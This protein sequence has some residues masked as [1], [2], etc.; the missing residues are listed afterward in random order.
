[1]NEW[2]NYLEYFDPHGVCHLLGVSLNLDVEGQ[3]D[4]VLLLVLQHHGSFH[5]VALHHRAD[6]YAGVLKL[7]SKQMKL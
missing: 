2:L 1:M 6:L 7:K 5:H 3:D 4:G